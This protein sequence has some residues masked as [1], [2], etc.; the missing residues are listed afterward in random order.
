M[1][2]RAAHITRTV[3]AIEIVAVIIVAVA[4]PVVIVAIDIDVGI[5]IMHRAVIAIAWVKAVTVMRTV[6]IWRVIGP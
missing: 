4:V 3:I 1:R 6:W 5:T 2:N